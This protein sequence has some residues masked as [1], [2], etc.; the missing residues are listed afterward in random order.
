MESNNVALT[1]T[2]SK[3][4]SD[5]PHSEGCAGVLGVPSHYQPCLIPTTDAPYPSLFL[6]HR[7]RQTAQ[8]CLDQPHSERQPAPSY[9]DLP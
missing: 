4:T 8:Q 2:C 7:T 3:F 5:I 6:L 1:P 9:H